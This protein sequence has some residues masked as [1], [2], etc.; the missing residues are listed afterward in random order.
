MA[1]TTRLSRAARLTAAVVAGSLGL[2]MLAGC[3]GAPD[4]QKTSHSPSAA[5]THS[6]KPTPSSTPTPTETPTPVALTC[7][8]IVSAQQLYDF[9]PNYGADPGYKPEDGGLTAKAVADAGVSCGF[10]NQTSRSVV[11][12]A[13]ATPTD[14]QLTALKNA[15]VT[16]SNVVPTY[17][18]PPAV[19]GYF[20]V[21]GGAGQA[22][23]FTGKYW[24]VVSST[25]FAE[26]GDPQPLVASVLSNL[27]Q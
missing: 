4:S 6:S 14:S 19:E 18:A 11:E 7:D 15:A 5:A 17:G 16:D 13:V 24:V 2:A 25:D 8:Q 10:M 3:T 26:P 1:A 27:P 12:V 22:Q 20:G 21:S 9:N 23:V